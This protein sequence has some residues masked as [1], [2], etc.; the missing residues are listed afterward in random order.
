MSGW[1]N[2]LKESKLNLIAGPCVLESKEHAFDMSGSLTEICDEL[3][4]NFIYKTSF[5]KANR[6]S[7]NSYR[8]AYGLQ[9]SDDLFGKLECE[10]LT[11]VHESWQPEVLTNVDVLQVP[12]FL[13]RQTD[14]IKACADTGKPT[15]IKKGQFT[16][17]ESMKWA[18]EKHGGDVLLT[19]R[20]TFFGYG[21]LV[22]DMLSLV[23]M[24]EYA[25]V[26]FDM[27]HSV[28]QVSGRV[29]GGNRE[30]APVLGRA[31]VAIGIDGLFL[32]VH[33]DPDNAPSDGPNMIILKDLKG[34]LETILEYATIAQQ[35]EHVICNDEV[36]GS[37]PGG[38]STTVRVSYSGNTSAF[39]ADAE[40]SILSTRSNSYWSYY[41]L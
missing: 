17:P 11:D 40:S 20:G 9:S 8:G 25:P 41:D 10:V 1:Y 19:E 33:N 34:I 29:T 27:T 35:V 15:N 28:Q 21:N 30:F 7:K 37:I 31:A 32:E 6:T 3:E 38:G 14:L 5:D 13:C 24:K 16:S 2:K 12:A 36:P 39:Q 26:I 4:I 23:K 22:V 18:V